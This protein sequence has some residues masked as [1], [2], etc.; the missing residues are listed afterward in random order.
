MMWRDVKAG[1]SIEQVRKQIPGV[2]TPTKPS[3]L[4]GGLEGLLEYTGFQ[5]VDLDFNAT[6]Y[7][8]EAKLDRIFLRPVDNPTGGMARSVARRLLASLT[9]KYGT[10]ISS[11][12][13]EP[14]TLEA[15]WINQGVQIKFRFDQF[16]EDGTG[17][18]ILNYV[19]PQD[20]SNI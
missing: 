17:F 4:R 5:I 19:A 12:N 13:K 16:T 3:T 2:S 14:F 8:K 10:P 15:T 20:A 9:A 18:F 6:F 7:F 11:S 1:S